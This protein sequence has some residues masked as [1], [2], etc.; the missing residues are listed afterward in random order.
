MLTL[1]FLTIATCLALA[2]SVAAWEGYDQ[3][4]GYNATIESGNL[5]RPGQDI[6]V[7]DWHTNQYHYLTVESMSRIG[8]DVEVEV[9][10]WNTNDW[11]TFT[12][13][14]RGP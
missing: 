10:D 5:V 8:R 1:K 2:S 7:Y 13:E 9:Y 3:Y 6:E 14:G 4:T 12:F 11:R